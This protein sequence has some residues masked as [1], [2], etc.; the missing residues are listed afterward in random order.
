MDDEEII[1]R[2]N[3][4]DENI[5]GRPLIGFIQKYVM[6]AKMLY[7]YTKHVTV[8]VQIHHIILYFKLK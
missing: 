3:N 2:T 8:L 6:L 7:Y 5:H 4:I 1:H